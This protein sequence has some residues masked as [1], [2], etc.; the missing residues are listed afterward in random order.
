MAKTF[1]VTVGTDRKDFQITL[2]EMRRHKVR[3]GENITI[4]L[5]RT[6]AVERLNQGLA[7]ASEVMSRRERPKGKDIMLGRGQ[8]RWVHKH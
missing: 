8:C 1:L 5:A 6:I 7:V 4:D 3:S 2:S